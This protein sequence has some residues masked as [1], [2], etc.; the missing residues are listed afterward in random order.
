MKIA[1]VAILLAAASAAPKDPYPRA[2][3]DCH[4]GDSRLSVQLSKPAPAPLLAKLQP[5]APKGVKL[6]GKHPA[7]AFAFKDIP[8]KCMTCHATT[9]KNAPPFFRMMHVLHVPDVQ[10]TSC[11][12][13]NTAT[14]QPAIPSGS[15]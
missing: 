10:C 5:L 15:E 6:S 3:I 13:M 12:K 4:K 2:C 14:G 9:S 11:H 8:A 7:V 1:L